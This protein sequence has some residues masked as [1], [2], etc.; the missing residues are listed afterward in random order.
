MTET[1]RHMGGTLHGRHGSEIHPSDG[2]MS[3]MPFK[4]VFGPM[5]GTSGTIASPNSPNGRFNLPLASHPPL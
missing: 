3:L 4:H 5:A 2:E 1:V